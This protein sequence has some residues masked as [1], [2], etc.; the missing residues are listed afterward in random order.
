MIN[1]KIREIMPTFIIGLIMLVQTSCVSTNIEK[2]NSGEILKI[3]DIWAGCAANYDMITVPPY[4]FIAYYDTAHY[5]TIAQRKLSEKTWVK[6]RLNSKVEWDAHNYISMVLDKKGCLHVSGNMHV[7]DL[8]YFQSE[9]PYDA[10]SLKQMHSL[11]GD[12]EHAV[13]YPEFFEAPNGDLIF[14][15]RTGSSGK[16]NQIYNR[17][18]ADTES[19]SRLLDIPLVDG[20][21]KSNAYLHGPKHGP[22][23]FFHLIWVWRTEL[24]ANAN[25]NIS[26]A[27]S[28]D[29]INWQKGDGSLQ[30]LPIRM[31]NCDVI[32]P[33]PTYHGLLNGNTKIGF[34]A[35]KRMIAS[36][37][38]YDEDGNIQIYNARNENGKWEI[39]QATDWNWRWDF[40]GWGSIISRVGL[41]GVDIENNKLVQTFY[42][43]SIGNQKF[44]ID[45]ENLKA[46]EQ[47]EI[48][49]N[50]PD[51]LM[52]LKGGLDQSYV[53]LLED[54]S[55]EY[56]T[57]VLR[58]ETLKRNGDKGYD[59]IPKP[60]PLELY[61]FNEI[62]K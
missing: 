45:E 41:S 43:D 31:D 9:K 30:E 51:S 25:C 54:T 18:N 7:V 21:G 47:I 34:D 1:K 5:M 52:N 38:K 3:D 24:D 17:Y 27:K 23:G 60:Q 50:F 58:W 46:I 56:G 55:D 37:H 39:Y 26:Y 8:I 40:C 15:Y 44:I 20:E 28:K 4:Q 12:E 29:L 16:G 48:E 35:Q 19:W 33:I 32:D 59:F 53:H 62:K 10:T 49:K 14:T 61:H 42:I 11:I 36:Y 6:T 57:F 13:T 22:D 2:E